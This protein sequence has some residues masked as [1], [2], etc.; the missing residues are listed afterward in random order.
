MF[1][2]IY[3]ATRHRGFAL[4]LVNQHLR[5][6]SFDIAFLLFASNFMRGRK[7]QRKEHNLFTHTHTL[8]S[9]SL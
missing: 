2:A 8:H 6:I 1:Y 3:M 9:D 7:S 4:V 5:S